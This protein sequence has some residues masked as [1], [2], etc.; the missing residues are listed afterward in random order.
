MGI[1]V[2]G[3]DILGVDIWE[4]TFWEEPYFPSLHQGTSTSQLVYMNEPQQK[5]TSIKAP[6][7]SSSI[8]VVGELKMT[9]LS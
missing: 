3:V 2:S 6:E 8:Y 7:P 4:L 9:L 1:D 5:V